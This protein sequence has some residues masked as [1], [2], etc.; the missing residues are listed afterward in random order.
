MNRCISVGVD[1]VLE[2]VLC[3]LKPELWS[4]SVHFFLPIKNEMGSVSVNLT[5]VSTVAFLTKIK[6]MI[7]L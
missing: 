7:K 1:T 4:Y 3:S 6:E 5:P 2:L